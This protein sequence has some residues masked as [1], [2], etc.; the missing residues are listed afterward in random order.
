[1]Q[2]TLRKRLSIND[3]SRGLLE[4]GIET[5]KKKKLILAIKYK[6]FYLLSLS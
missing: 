4:R 3:I 6:Y 5:I 2:F 1:M